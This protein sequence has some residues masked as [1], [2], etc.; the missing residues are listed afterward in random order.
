MTKGAAGANY[1]GTQPAEL[2]TVRP[3]HAA[4]A[5]G[6]QAK[7]KFAA[8][9]RKLVKLFTSLASGAALCPVKNAQI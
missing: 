8:D 2:L 9:G 1:P 7:G 3:A 5:R 6:S 4:I